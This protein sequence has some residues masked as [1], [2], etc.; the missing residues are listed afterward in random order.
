MENIH[1]FGKKIS[2]GDLNDKGITK[3]VHNRRGLVWNEEM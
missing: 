3:G 2:L 1:H